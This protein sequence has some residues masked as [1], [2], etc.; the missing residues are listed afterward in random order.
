ML[1]ISS[2]II[3]KEFRTQLNPPKQV[4]CIGYGQNPDNGKNYIVGACF[5]NANNRTY[6]ATYLFDDIIFMGNITTPS[7]KQIL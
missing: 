7:T 3:G 1:N 5:D 2:D 4:T 6:I